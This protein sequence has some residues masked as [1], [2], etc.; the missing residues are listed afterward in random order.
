MASKS[1][2]S[3]MGGREIKI[4]CLGSRTLP[5]RDLVALQGSLKDLSVEDFERLA[6]EL[7]E[8]GL[9]DPPNVWFDK[10]AKKWFILD[11]HQRIRVIRV[12]VDER[13]F[14]CGDIPVVE[15]FADSVE[16]AKQKLLG[17]ASVYGVVTKQGLYEFMSEADVTLEDL[18]RRYSFPSVN[19]SDFAAEYFVD[20]PE[21]LKHPSWQSDL[22]RM[23]RVKPMGEAA[24]SIIKV[25]CPA[26]QRN[27]VEKKIEEAIIGL[28]AR[29]E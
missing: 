16:E 21:H 13:G 25:I 18:H 14:F 19:L 28:G 1:T 5:W 24:E 27:V 20:I 2:N 7:I 3:Q 17:L 12:L 23:D 9:T 4:S 11:G 6:G 29:I 8:Q 15:V 10:K 22:E 26:G